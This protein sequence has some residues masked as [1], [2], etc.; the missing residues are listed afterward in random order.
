MNR[1]FIVTS[2]LIAVCALPCTANAQ[3]TG[4]YGGLGVG[5]TKF[6]V[7]CPAA[8]GA[9]CDTKD[10]GFKFFSG[11]E[12]G[13]IFAAEFGLTD[14]GETSRN[15]SSFS[16]LGAELTGLARWSITN[17]LS[18]FGKAGGYYSVTHARLTGFT[19]A[20]DKSTDWTYGLGLQMHFANNL[21]ARLEWQRYKNIGEAGTTGKTDVDYLGVSA[22]MKF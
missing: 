19:E 1:Q 8:P 6:K 14:L 10:M 4:T 16:T 7:G 9:G 12:F 21:G 11:F 17:N 18:I 22:I 2:S 3:L 20:I 13:R 15:G 5:H